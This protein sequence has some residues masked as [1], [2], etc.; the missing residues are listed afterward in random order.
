MLNRNFCIQSI[1]F[2]LLILQTH[3]LAQISPGD[4]TTAHAKFEGM[5]NCTKCHVLG[6]KV[7]DS[8]C[9]DC[10]TE[11]KTLIDQHRGYHSSDEVQEKRM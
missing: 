6:E 2:L 5:S 7:Q 10:H 4:L 9:L 3:L 1:V 11:I 8:K